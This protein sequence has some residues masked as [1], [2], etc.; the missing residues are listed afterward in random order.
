MKEREWQW[1]ARDGKSVFARS[2]APDDEDAVQAVIVLIHGKGEHSG[3]YRHLAG[4]FTAGGIAVMAFDQLGHG[5][6]EG[7]RGHADSYEELMDGIDRL[8]EEAQTR[9][10]GKPIFLYGHS[11]GGNIMINYV[12]RRRPQLAGAIATGPWLK[13]A[14]SDKPLPL[15]IWS[16]VAKQMK[17]KRPSAPPTYLT[18]DPDMLARLTADPL[19]HGKFSAKLFFAIRR[20]GLWALEHADELSVPMLILHGGDDTVTSLE[21][22]RHFSERADR[23]CTFQEWPGLRH[24]LH[25]ERHREEIFAAIKS[26]IRDQSSEAA[27][28]SGN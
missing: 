21:A 1:P 4:N 20:A 25:N 23:L 18:S 13:L 10:S 12:L 16:R 2:W 19:G 22:S 5:L 17:R 11:M 26:W 28:T 9:Y 7:K 8:L 14:P 3:R 6:T 15:V 24:E 27:G